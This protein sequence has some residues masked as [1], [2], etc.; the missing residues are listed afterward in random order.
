MRDASDA[1]GDS[2][3]QTAEILEYRP[4]GAE[5]LARQDTDGD[6]GVSSIEFEVGKAARSTSN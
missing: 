5:F 6:G 4:V 1:N 2:L 3:L